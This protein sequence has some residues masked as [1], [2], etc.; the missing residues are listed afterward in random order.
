MKINVV[1]AIMGAGKT[2]ASINFIN[3]SDEDVKFLYITPYLTEVKR[4]MESCQSK[5]FKQPESFGTKLKGIKYLFDNGFNIVSTHALFR[6]FDE[7]IIDL[8]FTN[9]YTLIM[10]EV[11]DVIEPYNI[12]KPDLATVLEKYASV[13]DMGL[14]KWHDREYN[15]RFSEVKQLCDLDCLAIYGGSA[16][17]WLFPVSTFRAFRNIYILTYM[18]QAQTQKYYYDFFGIEYNYLYVKNDNGKYLFT[19][20]KFDYI[21]LDYNKL[22]HICDVDKLNTVGD[23]EYALSKTWY[24]R[25]QGNQLIKKLKNS[26]SNYFKNYT[27]TKSNENLWTTFK[28]YQLLLSGKGYAKS[29]LSS[30][31]RATNEYRDRIAVAYLVNKFFNPF[32]KNFFVQHG[33]EV[34][35]DSF[36]VSEMLQFIWRSAIREGKEIWLYIPSS[37]MRY[38]LEKWIKETSKISNTNTI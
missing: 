8:A 28:D 9:N 6:N 20:D 13:D 30:N 12:T 5:K 16:M 1:D 17:M 32:I 7:E 3:E 24:D 15:G 33:V 31:T 14:M 10:D 35:E 29:F 23:M 21:N 26:T 22:I 25:N 36:A 38:L 11:T 2:S 27:K 18:F 19:N 37:R 4:I 34:D